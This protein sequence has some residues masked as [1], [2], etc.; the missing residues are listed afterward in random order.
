LTIITIH[1]G[2]II[3][4]L[5]NLEQTRAYLEAAIAMVSNIFFI[6][7]LLF[8]VIVSVLFTVFVF[9]L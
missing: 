3:K 7:S 5:W 4:K 2:D 6:L 9:C 8:I 1:R